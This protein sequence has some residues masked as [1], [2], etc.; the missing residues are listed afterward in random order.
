[1]CA[2][3][4]VR[5]CV[6]VCM[7]MYVC[8]YV[9]SFQ[10]YP[11]LC[12][13]MD[14]AS[15]APLSMGFSGQEYWSGSP[16]LPQGNF[17]SPGIKSASLQHWKVGSFPLAPPGKLHWENNSDH[18]QYLFLY[19]SLFLFLNLQMRQNIDKIPI[20]LIFLKNLYHNTSF[21]IKIQVG[22]QPYVKFSQII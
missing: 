1:M 7:C 5:V 22:Y 3:L 17:P 15:Q 10:S 2:C 12:D 16:C 18:L 4:C 13:P 20:L 21:V 14:C 9:L 19:Q 11:T 6:G 8:A